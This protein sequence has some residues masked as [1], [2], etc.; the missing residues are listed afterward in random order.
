MRAARVRGRISGALW[1]FIP[2]KKK[3]GDR[4]LAAIAYDR[5]GAGKV[6]LPMG[7]KILPAP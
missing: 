1:G 2:R 5:Y 3:E 4:A 6:R 7:G